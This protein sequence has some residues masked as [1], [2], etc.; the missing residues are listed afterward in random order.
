MI[1]SGFI[2]RRGLLSGLTVF[3]AARFVAGP[4]N[5][6]FSTNVNVVNVYATVRD[7]KGQ[8]VRNLTKDDFL[9]EEE[10]RPQ[11]IR[12]F[13]QESN[14]PLTIGL[15]IDTSGSTRNVLPD[16]RRASFQFLRQVMRQEK[17]LAFIIHFDFET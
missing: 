13:S 3:G 8:V 15:L 16:E 11:A 17:D 2:S 7:K 5:P 9:L 14:L 6:T 4:Q 1:K 12:Y 10:G